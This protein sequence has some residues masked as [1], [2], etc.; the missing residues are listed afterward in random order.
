MISQDLV[1]A[2]ICTIAVT[3]G[4][5][6]LFYPAWIAA[7]EEELEWEENPLSVPQNAET[8]LSLVI[9][10]YNEENR[11]SAMLKS[12]HAFLASGKGHDVIQRL[13]KCAKKGGYPPSHKIE[14]IIVDDGSQDGTCKVVEAVLQSLDSNHAWRVLS[15]KKN[16]GKG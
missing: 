2:I 11:I 5:T 1:V 3:T 10:A 7:I 16:S 15:L 14:W 6:W 4:L 8:I 12:A 9:P 13:N